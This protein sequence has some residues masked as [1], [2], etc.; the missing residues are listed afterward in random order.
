M[1]FVY[2]MDHRF[3]DDGKAGRKKI[4]E[5]KPAHE[6]RAPFPNNDK[7]TSPNKATYPKPL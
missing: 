6:Q 1:I 7:M 4:K 2:G 5:P 3:Q